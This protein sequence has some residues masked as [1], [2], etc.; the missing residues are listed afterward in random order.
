MYVCAVWRVSIQ[1]LTETK[2]VSALFSN[3]RTLFPAS[4]CTLPRRQG[5]TH[6][7]TCCTSSH[8]ARRPCRSH[9]LPNT[10]KTYPIGA[11]RCSHASP[12][13]VVHPS[14]CTVPRASPLAPTALNNMRCT[15]G[16]GP[17]RMSP[18]PSPT[19]PTHPTYR[20]EQ[21]T[22]LAWRQALYAHRP[23]THYPQ[24]F[25]LNIHRAP[26]ALNSTHCPRGTSPCSHAASRPLS[27]W[28]NSTVSKFRR[29]PAVSLQGNTYVCTYVHM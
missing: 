24:S 5:I 26:T 25:P 13:A 9:L 17:A 2:A 1:S 10:L 27:P 3:T 11:R 29:G 18:P 7:A 14:H 28:K 12:S 19:A 20:V 22:L 15:C 16:T 8:T 23:Q 21:H 6:G 4:R